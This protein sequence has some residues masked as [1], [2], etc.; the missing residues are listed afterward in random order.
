M[1]CHCTAM[2][3]P[4][5]A[6]AVTWQ[7]HGSHNVSWSMAFK[8]VHGSF[9]TLMDIYANAMAMPWAFDV[10]A[11]IFHGADCRVVP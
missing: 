8:G 6:M 4:A 11:M 9:R 10:V 2:G 3:S 7:R 5:D 1:A